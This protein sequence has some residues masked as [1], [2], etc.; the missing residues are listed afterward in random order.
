M[1]E[2][3]RRWR[4]W[5][6]RR[7]IAASGAFDT[8][9]YL[10]YNHDLAGTSVDP[11]AHYVAF[12]GFESRMPNPVFDSGFYLATYFPGDADPPNPLADYLRRL[13][14]SPRRPARWFDPNHY[15][16][17]AGDVGR[18]PMRHYLA[19]GRAAHDPGPDF[20]SADW[21]CRF[22]DL[23]AETT[24]LGFFLTDYRVTAR[25]DACTSYYVSGWAQRRTGPPIDITILVN[26]EERGRVTPWIA[27]DDIS[28]VLQLDAKG[29]VFVFP[30]RLADGD[31]VTL[32]DEFDETIVGCET[33]Y[34]IP[35]LGET[36]ALYGNRA[37]IAATYL[38]GK[39]VEIGAFTQPTDLPPDLQ[40]IFFDRFPAKRL[41]ELYDER[42]CRPMMEPDVVGDAQTL[43]G[44]ADA[45]FDF[46][47]ANHVLEHLEDPI[48]FLKR[49]SET[50]ARG[51]RAMIAIP[52]RRYGADSKRVPTSFDHLVEDHECGAERSRLGHYLEA[53]TIEGLDGEAA[54]TY[55]AA[56]PP[57]TT[58]LHYHVWDAEEF[59]AFLH[60]AI[61]RYALP[62]SLIY[63]SATVHEITVILEKSGEPNDPA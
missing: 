49:V 46:L 4:Q 40:V 10:A 21:L 20:A 48:A 52:D 51:G 13:R 16:R 28:S 33:T 42:W 6:E 50:L 11:L 37:A 35:T 8:S 45:A 60:A 56:V 5:R 59:V 39:G 17:Q 62:L 25:I 15:R 32:R 36:D 29:F 61:A 58:V 27:R 63:T 26:G 38:A 41:R 14:R 57:D 19:A 55:A 54:Q 7:L 53:A 3:A 18:D 22:P 44:L 34:R 24:P 2:L 47:V 9:F 12:G 1:R 30:Q 31:A 23:D 43:D